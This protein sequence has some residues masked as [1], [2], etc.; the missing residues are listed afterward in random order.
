MNGG[1]NPY[2]EWLGLS[3][4]I[5]RPNYYELLGLRSLENDQEIIKQA[6]DQRAGWLEELLPGEHGLMARRIL[7][8]IAAARSCLLNAQAKADYDQQLEQ[9]SP[10]QPND[11]P[12]PPFTSPLATERPLAVPPAPALAVDLPPQDCQAEPPPPQTPETRPRPVAAPPSRRPGQPAIRPAPRSKVATT[13]V[14]SP[15]LRTLD[16]ESNA[17]RVP[18]IGRMTLQS[19]LEELDQVMQQCRELYLSC[20]PKG[21]EILKGASLDMTLSQDRLHKYLLVKLC[22]TIAEADGRWT[23]E[24]Q[25]CAAA[26][27]RHV[28]IAFSDQE[29]DKIAGYVHKQ[30]GKLD[31]QQ[32]LQPFREIPVLCDKRAELQTVILRTA[33]LI[34]KADGSLLP[35]ETTILER[36]QGLL[37]P[38]PRRDLDRAPHWSEED[39]IAMAGGIEQLWRK[40]DAAKPLAATPAAS[41]AS[42]L[43]NLQRLDAL[44]GLRQVKQEI[45]GLANAASRRDQREQAG[46][47]VGLHESHLVFVGGEGT[48]K[49]TVARL[50]CDILVAAGALEHGRLVEVNSRGLAQ[51][52]ADKAADRMDANFA[53]AIGGTLLIDHAG[54]LLSAGG[55]PLSAAM[56]V[57]LQRMAGHRGQL[58]VILADD[59]DRLLRTIHQRSDLASAFNRHLRFPSYG[60][61]E[62]GR[63]FQR[64]CDRNH[65]QVSR[66]AQIKLLLGFQWRLERDGELFGNGHLV[67]Q[68]FEDAVYC[69]GHRVAGIST[70]T[71]GLLTSL[72]DD[73]ILI[74]GVPAG[75]WS[76]L[77]DP[78][79]MFTIHCPGC[80][81]ANQVGSDFLGIQV[82]CKRCHHRFV[83]AWGEPCQ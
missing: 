67:R 68:V 53:E 79:R 8:E 46:Q 28:G 56:R 57:L 4:E 25:R 7:D 60:V 36:I 9:R 38:D 78:G 77:A 64:F 44:V 39:T 47:P 83:C 35:R 66:L 6:A 10:T 21:R 5:R 62:L 32:L 65:Y 58:V 50:L 37:R 82:E 75:V 31:W 52:H 18:M 63:I 16:D 19:V 49:T 27:L 69:L 76:N 42:L 45:R 34:A 1:F 22:A 26:V 24:E 54:E 72:E 48:G 3:A 29:L 15:G 30:A 41:V 71:E 61:S 51:N 12:L 14:P 73:D 11:R 81:S 59:S 80:A 43:E 74:D 2:H 70:L 33:N 55:Q 13:A 17:P 23:Y 20:V 40:G